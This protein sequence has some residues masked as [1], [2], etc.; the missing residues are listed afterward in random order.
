MLAEHEA[1]YFALVARDAPVAQAAALMHLTTTERR[2]RE[3]VRVSPRLPSSSPSVGGPSE[4]PCA[5]AR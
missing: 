1:I 3:H 5:P 2:L 4:K